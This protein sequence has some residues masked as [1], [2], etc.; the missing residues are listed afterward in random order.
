MSE[1]EDRQ[2][3]EVETRSKGVAVDNVDF[4]QRIIT[5]IAV[6]YEQPTMVPFRGEVWNEVFSRSA[7][8]GIE[9]RQRRIPATASLVV[10]NPNHEK[11]H[12]VGRVIEAR[13]DSEVGLLADV[14]ISRTA[15]GDETLQLASDEALSASVGFLI[16]DP[17]RDQELDRRSKTRR[18][19]RAFLDH[20][21]FVG[22]PA[23][24]GAKILSMRSEGDLPLIA[25]PAIDDL[26][27]DPLFKWAN[28]QIQK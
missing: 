23:Y 8:N 15:V 20:L 18:I 10:P 7:F 16:K 25:T 26:M 27:N 5:V 1:N 4:G 12:L 24:E 19:N 28:E 22:E 13:A 14:K 3:L 9:T 6:P 21:A 2:V 11:G 17:Y